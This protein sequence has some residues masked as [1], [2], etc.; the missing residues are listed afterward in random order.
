V[1]AAL[2]ARLPLEVLDDVRDVDL[3]S[4]DPRVLEALSKSFPAGPTKGLP[5]R[6]S[7]SPGC[8]P[9]KTSSAFAEPSPKT[10]C[11]AVL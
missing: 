10:V 3:A 5:W 9:T 7:W 11:V 2:A 8:S 4:L 1:N 6:S